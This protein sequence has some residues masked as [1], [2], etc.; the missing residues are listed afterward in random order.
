MQEK[1]IAESYQYLNDLS[2]KVNHSNQLVSY[3][4]LNKRWTYSKLS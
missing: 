2:N 4:E 3:I 1:I